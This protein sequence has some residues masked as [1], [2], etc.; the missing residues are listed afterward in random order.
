MKHRGV[1]LVEV[2]DTAIFEVAHSLERELENLVS[3]QPMTT[4]TV[5]TIESLAMPAP[6]RI[7]PLPHIS[8]LVVD[9][10]NLES[11]LPTAPCPSWMV[12]DLGERVSAA[13]G[14]GSVVVDTLLVLLQSIL[15]R[16][17]V[18]LELLVKS[19]LQW[20]LVHFLVPQAVPSGVAY[21]SWAH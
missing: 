17:T 10:E 1:N 3:F 21:G 14:P 5:A 16:A 2:Q 6:A 9:I 15:P 8:L 11:S 20:E 19:Q 18:L 4:L 7:G 12:P 13:V